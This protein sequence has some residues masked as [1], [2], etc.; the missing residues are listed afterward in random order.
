VL[1]LSR[2]QLPGFTS[3][4]PSALVCCPQP[5]GRCLPPGKHTVQRIEI[6]Y[7][8]GT[9][10]SPVPAKSP[11]CEGNQRLTAIGVSPRRAKEF[12]MSASTDQNQIESPPS[13]ANLAVGMEWYFH[14]LRQQMDLHREFTVTW[15]AAVTSLSSTVLGQWQTVE[16]I[17]AA[18]ADQ[19]AE[20]A[21]GAER[22]TRGIAEQVENAAERTLVSLTDHQPMMSSPSNQPEATRDPSSAKS[23]GTSSEHVTPDI[24]DEL[25]ELIVDEDIKAAI[26]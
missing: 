23:A 15:A 3:D 5:G 25:L 16:H 1:T 22:V 2:K 21:H 18:H 11:P 13:G 19:L 24:F 14:F 6:L 7:I 12:H 10:I 20:R 9:F 4:V 26:P 17:L 8:V